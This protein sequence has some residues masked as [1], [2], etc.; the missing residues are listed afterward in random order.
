M[1]TDHEKQLVFTV[2]MPFARHLE[3]VIV[4]RPAASY[5]APRWHAHHDNAH[6]GTWRSDVGSEREKGQEDAACYFFLTVK[7]CF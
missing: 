5:A 1:D 7:V 6:T 4:C 2:S 3:Q